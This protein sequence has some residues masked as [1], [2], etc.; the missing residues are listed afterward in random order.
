MVGRSSSVYCAFVIVYTDSYLRSG[1]TYTAINV[2]GIGK[3]RI[4]DRLSSACSRRLY[5]SFCFARHSN[6]ST[7][8]SSKSVSYYGTFG[9]S[10]RH[11]AIALLLPICSTC[12][13]TLV[14]KGNRSIFSS[15]FFTAIGL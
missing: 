11:S 4:G 10:S 13:K 15:S 12:P 8:H 7:V 5:T 2:F 1:Y 3:R 6:P 14:V 9:Y